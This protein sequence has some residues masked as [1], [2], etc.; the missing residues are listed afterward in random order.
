MKV[1]NYCKKEVQEEHFNQQ[2]CSEKCKNGAKLQSQK[3]YKLSKKGNISNQKWVQSKRRKENERNYRRKEDY[4]EQ[5]RKRVRRFNKTL[6]GKILKANMDAK[7]RSYLKNNGKFT[8]IEWKNKLK[9]FNYRCVNCGTDKN[10][11][12]DH[13]IPLSK[14]GSNKISNIQPLCGLCNSKKS[15]KL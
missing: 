15:N 8:L 4:K 3:K 6:K 11:T 5:N 12:I 10:L 7:R 13:I 2:R 1:C 9:E 14:G